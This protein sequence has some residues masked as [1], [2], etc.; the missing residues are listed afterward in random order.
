MIKRAFSIIEL[1]VCFAIIFVLLTISVPKFMFFNK[2]I[3]TSQTDKLFATFS[4]LQ[5]K[6]IASNQEQKLTFNLK[7]NTYSH[8]NK[9]YKLPEVVRFGCLPGAKGP[10]SSPS[11]EIKKSITF[12]KLS[13]SQFCMSFYVDGKV[14]PGTAYLI[15]KDQKFMMALTCPISQVSCI[16]KYKYDDGRWVCCTK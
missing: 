10:P 4:Y 1:L 5:Q 3:L 6:A 9:S 13:E 2:F 7:N 15:D 8:D 16:R 11:K 12:A 14:S